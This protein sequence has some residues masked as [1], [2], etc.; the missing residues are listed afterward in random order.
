MK[1]GGIRGRWACGRR[2]AA[3]ALLAACGVGA[4]APVTVEVVAGAVVCARGPDCDRRWGR[5]V[6]WVVANSRWRVRDATPFIIKTDGPSD[7]LSASVTIRRFPGRDGWDRIVFEAGC[8]PGRVTAIVD[9]AHH[10]GRRWSNVVG[11]E[12]KLTG[13]FRACRRWRRASSTSWLAERVA[14]SAQRRP[15]APVSVS[16]QPAT[17][18]S[19]GRWQPR[20]RPR[21]PPAAEA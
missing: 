1:R 13:A 7:T 12:A 11:T 5:A 2:L 9:H 3:L 14:S 21:R 19:D 20:P 4:P 15:A 10:G 17:P 8:S 18:R 16:Q 6:E